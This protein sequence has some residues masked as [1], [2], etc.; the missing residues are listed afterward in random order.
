MNILFLIGNG[1]DINVGLNT[2]FK[3]A[4]KSY[5]NEENKDLR[6]QK[7]K[8]DIRGNF[9]NWS[10]FEKQLGI[11][12][13]NYSSTTIDD[14]CFCIKDFKESLIRHLKKEEDRVDFNAQKGKIVKVF[15]KSIFNFY[16][17]L[18]NNSKNILR[19]IITQSANNKNTLLHNFITFNYT[20]VLDKCLEIIKK[21]PLRPNI[22]TILHIHGTI[23]KNSIMGVDNHSQIGNK[24]LSNNNRINWT[25]VKPTSNKKLKNLNDREGV[26]LI[27]RSD[28]I[29]LFGLSL[30]ETD[31]TWWEIIGSWLKTGSNRQLV[32]FNVVNQWNE[33]HPDEEIE[34]IDAIEEKFCFAAGF[35]EKER[36]TMADR[37]HIG[38]NTDMFKVT[39]PSPNVDSRNFAV[40]Q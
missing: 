36:E 29:C 35:S 6:I 4:L 5:L 24:E 38:F 22:G 14:Y 18:T 31:K 15:N 40:V 39:L 37:I 21:E 34:N 13:E 3:D 19:G 25:I 17:G 1:F 8:N 7:F 32:I 20:S 28:I 26:N 30:G 9:E 16:D 11:Y 12:T 33:I 10:D 2:R 27:S 23:S